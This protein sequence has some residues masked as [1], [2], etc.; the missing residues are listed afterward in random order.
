MSWTRP[1]SSFSSSPGRASSSRS[2]SYSVAA[3]ATAGSPTGRSVHAHTGA[4][5]IS[6]SG[7]PTGV[8]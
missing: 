2:R 3:P 7:I 8:P 6:L 5:A 4:L 1:P